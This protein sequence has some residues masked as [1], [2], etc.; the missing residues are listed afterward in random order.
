M[1]NIGITGNSG[2]IGKN[3]SLVIKRYP[4]SFNLIKFDKSY[5]KDLELLNQ[6]VTKCDVIVHLAA[7]SRHPN[8][9]CLYNNNVQITKTLIKVMT[10][11]KVKPYV[12]FTSSIH[13]KSNSEYG[14]SK[15][16]EYNILKSWAQK[17]KSNFSCLVLSNVFGPFCKPNY[18]S[19]IATFCYKL[20]NNETPKI[21]IDKKMNLTYVENLANY[22][23]DKIKLVFKNKNI[24]NEYL[25]VKYDEEIKVSEVLDLLVD[26]KINY[27][28]YKAKE[29]FK[30]EFIKNLF[31]TFNSYY[32]KS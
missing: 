9:G 7:L 4:T 3:L 18:A 17:T 22:M 20:S 16:F 15:L 8:K 26:F 5:F 31:S 6:F 14:R 25:K 13:D 19:F 11:Q 32:E 29:K 27:Q 21:E 2:F 28:E 10:D 24:V 30:N 1:L 23:L 12:I